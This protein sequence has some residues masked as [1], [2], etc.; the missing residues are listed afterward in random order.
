[1]LIR[2]ETENRRTDL[3][4]GFLGRWRRNAAHAGV[5]AVVLTV[6]LAAV[7]GLAVWVCGLVGAGPTLSR[8]R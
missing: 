7:V 2:D 6:L 4:N 1:M 3:L 8:G 5:A